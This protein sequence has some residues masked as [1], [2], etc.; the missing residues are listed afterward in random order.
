MLN[1]FR[2]EPSNL[3]SQVKTNLEGQGFRI[4]KI[5]GRLKGTREG[6]LWLYFSNASLDEFN[7][8]LAVKEGLEWAMSFTYRRVE[9]GLYFPSVVSQELL[10]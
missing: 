5:G 10:Q 3:R 2:Q 4:K 9:L 6:G 7:G 1:D 8:K